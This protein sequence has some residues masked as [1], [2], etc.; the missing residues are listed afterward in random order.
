MRKQPKLKLSKTR[1]SVDASEERRREAN[2]PTQTWRETP[3]KKV[4]KITSTEP[5]LAAI[6]GLK[7][8]LRK[9]PLKRRRQNP[10]IVKTWLTN[11]SWP[12]LTWTTLTLKTSMSLSPSGLKS[13]LSE[14]RKV[15]SLTPKF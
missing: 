7:R 12:K 14:L 9:F 13:T 15:T 11:K 4:T 6:K 1:L 2:M 3:R 5:S 8:P 10:W